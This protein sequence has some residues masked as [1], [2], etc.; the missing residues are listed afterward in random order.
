[1]LSA[2]RRAVSVARAPAV[3]SARSATATMPV[4]SRSC[5]SAN[6]LG[7][8]PALLFSRTPDGDGSA[9]N[10]ARA[11]AALALA[12]GCEEDRDRS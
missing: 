5:L 9:L 4:V 7:L 10:S 1:M 6:G 8:K 2:S 3:D 11:A 12:S